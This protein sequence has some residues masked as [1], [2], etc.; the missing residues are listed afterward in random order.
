MWN[1]PNKNQLDKIPVLYSTE[2]IALEDKEIH[3]HFFMGGSDWYVA[4]CGNSHN[5][6]GKIV[7]NIF[8]GYVILNNDLQN[9]EWGYVSLSELINIKVGFVEVDRDIHWKVKKFKNINIKGE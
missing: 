7:D 6:D 8:F 1:K 2:N 4:E 5:M 9:A 3:M